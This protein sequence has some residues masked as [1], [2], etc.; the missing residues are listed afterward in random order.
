MRSLALFFAAIIALPAVAATSISAIP[1]NRG[2]RVVGQV[3]GDALGS[4]NMTAIGDVNGDGRADVAIATPFTTLSTVSAAGAAYVFFGADGNLGNQNITSLNGANGFKI[5]G[6]TLPANSQLGYFTS[7]VGDVNN[8]DV[9]DFLI[10]SVSSGL[11]K[12]YIIFGKPTG[13]NFPATVDVSNLGTAGVVLIGESNADGFGS[14]SVSGGGDV[15]GDGI[16]DFVMGASTFG[17]KGIAYLIFGR[18]SWPQTLS[19]ASTPSTSVVRFTTPNF[20][21]ALGLYTAIGSDINNDGRADIFI[22]AYGAD[23]TGTAAEGK[24]YVIFGRS[25]GVPFS[26]TQSVDTLDGSSGFYVSGAIANSGFGVA[27]VSLGDFNGDGVGDFAA[28]GRPTS[29]GQIAVIFGKANWDISTLNG[30]NGTIFEGETLGNSAGAYLAAPGDVNG[31]GKADLL[32]GAPQANSNAGKVYLVHGTSNSLS[33]LNNLSAIET[34]L[35]GEVFNGLAGSRIGPVSGVG[36]FSSADPFPD[37]VIA[38][39]ADNPQSAGDGYIV[40]KGN[41]GLFS[42]GFE[43]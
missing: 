16:D 43:N 41:D 8:D 17:F 10:G 31:D 25:S 3:S 5:V 42:N 36:K 4:H 40:T 39:E 18:S 12:A 7:G 37:F 9:S 34:T 14:D 32:I 28:S 33:S 19:M 23:V 15:N 30:L 11:G 6:T 26:A 27:P 35:S 13:Q 21:D 20:N 2:V 1:G 22:Q 38:S 24:L 29:A